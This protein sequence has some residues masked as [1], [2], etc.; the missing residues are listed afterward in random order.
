MQISG[1]DGCGLRA[2]EAEAVFLGGLNT[3]TAKNALH[4][5]VIYY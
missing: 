5:I 4:E 1:I 2:F 3:K